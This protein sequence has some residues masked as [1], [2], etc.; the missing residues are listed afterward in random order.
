M[1]YVYNKKSAKLTVAELPESA[2]VTIGG[3]DEGSAAQLAARVAVLHRAVELRVQATATIPFALTRGGQDV[4]TSSDWRRAG[5]LMT[6]P[7]RF[8]A[9]WAE[10][11]LLYGAAYAVI[12]PNAYGVKKLV[13]C[14][15]STIRVQYT[16]SGQ[17]AGFE[18]RTVSPTGAARIETIP[19][20]AMAWCW[21]TDASVEVGP[22]QHTPVTAALRA[23]GVRAGMQA[24]L[25][26]YFQ[27]GAVRS[28]LITVPTVTPE[29]ERRRLQAWW[30]DFISGV[31]NAFRGRVFSADVKPVT[32]GDGL[33]ALGQSELDA[34]TRDEIL[35]ALGVP[36]SLVYA[37]AANYATAQQDAKN[38]LLYAAIPD[39]QRIAEALN[40]TVFERRGLRFEFRPESLEV[41]QQEEQDR[42]GALLNYV[43]A[44]IRPS[45]AA[46]ILGIELP[47]GMDYSALDP[48]PEPEQPERAEPE[49]QQPDMRAIVE[50]GQWERK[51]INSLARGK[52]ALVPFDAVY[53]GE[54]T[55]AAITR[56]LA[57]CATPEHVRAVFAGARD[58]LGAPRQDEVTQL[59]EA[60]R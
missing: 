2:W 43:N 34:A 60:L 26:A 19:P 15:P 1:F 39:A 59:L 48:E 50:L 16:D 13:Y 44:G 9:L 22:S 41:M 40:A 46:Q 55:C 49:P 36:A 28:T 8:L 45:V 33:D 4:E 10:S 38:L 17:V 23:A 6:E 3:V 27:R 24:F 20:E 42:S 14:H 52:T 11:L 35:A 56:S 5:G 47:A 57:G 32:I 21:W 54:A 25:D 31:R 29:P 12:A 18:R 51:A 30:D 7:V 53:L 58:G 37:N